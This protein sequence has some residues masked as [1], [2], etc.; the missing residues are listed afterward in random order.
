VDLGGYA[1]HVHATVSLL[2]PLT[3]EMEQSPIGHGARRA[4]SLHTT[5]I[6]SWCLPLQFAS[7]AFSDTLRLI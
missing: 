4:S 7:L 3:G 5:T 6:C 1:G 2:S